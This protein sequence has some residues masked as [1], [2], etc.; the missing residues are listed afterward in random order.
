MIVAVMACVSPRRGLVENNTINLA[1]ILPQFGNSEDVPSLIKHD[2]VVNGGSLAL[3]NVT[4]PQVYYD[5]YVVQFLLLIQPKADGK[6]MTDVG[7][8][9]SFRDKAYGAKA[10]RNYITRMG[11]SPTVSHLNPMKNILE[12][13]SSHRL[14]A[15]RDRLTNKRRLENDESASYSP[16]FNK[17]SACLSTL[18]FL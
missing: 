8:R 12:N 2:T 11:A 9:N 5:G 4:V 16:C 7:S 14:F 15:C 17:F 13:F 18:K 10:I 1:S 3:A 6:I